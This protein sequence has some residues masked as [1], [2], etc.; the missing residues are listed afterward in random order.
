MRRFSVHALFALCACALTLAAA[1]A[2]SVAEDKLVRSENGDYSLRLPA[3]WD[4]DAE[5]S[6]IT[7]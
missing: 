1:S 6:A 2:K 7:A 3:A 5:G 4:A